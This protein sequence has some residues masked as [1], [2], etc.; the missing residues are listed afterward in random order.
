[1]KPRL[2]IVDDERAI[3]EALLERLRA[4]GYAAEAVGDG[5]SALHRL[6]AGIELCLLDLQL[7]GTSGLDVLRRLREEELA[8]T[9]LVL[10]AHGTVARAV[11]AMKLGAYDFLEKPVEPALLEEALRR[12]AERVALLRRELERGPAR[13]ATLVLED[14]RS[15]AL[16]EQARRAASS[17]ATVLLLGESGTGKE[18]LA[19][20]VHRSSERAAGPFVALNCAALPETLLES[21]LFGHERGAFTGAESRRIGRIEAAH[22]GTLFLDEVGDASPAVQ[23]RLLRVLQERCFERLGGRGSIEV[24][25]RLIAATNR[26]LEQAVRAGQFREDLYYRLAVI[27]LTLPPLRERPQDIEPL[28]R[29]FV[30]EFAAEVKRPQLALAPAAL[31]CLRRHTWPGNVR[32]LR[33][34]VERAVVLC[35]GERLEP[36]DLPPEVAGLQSCE[37]S[38]GG[39]HFHGQVE[40]FRRQV[41]SEALAAHGGNQTAAARALGL[42]RSY[43][44]RLLRKYDL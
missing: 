8:P 13:G 26:P 42:Q 11:E 12:A 18:V 28:A 30:A 25:L 33:N 21:E 40:H 27:A 35:A 3:R 14:P 23:T 34:A 4:R 22:G 39:E 6:R 10:T 7:P 38:A 19:R 20:E 43:L 44:A 5:E 17:S 16:L 36:E 9:V 29:A 31:D 15:L 1:V 24:D 2:L 37:D 32:E 41:L